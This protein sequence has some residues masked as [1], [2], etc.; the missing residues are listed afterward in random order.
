[1][2]LETSVDT[3]GA[4][5]SSCARESLYDQVY[6][7]SS[8]RFNEGYRTSIVTMYVVS[9]CKTR[10]TCTYDDQWT[11]SHEEDLLA[12]LVDLGRRLK[13]F[14]RETFFPMFGVD[15]DAIID[16]PKEAIAGTSRAR[17][18]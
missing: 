5:L 16:V 17:V 12:L 10:Y 8:E 13:S 18:S 11:R 9:G 4:I 1:V 2:C 7:M 14:E 3:E 6:N 15:N